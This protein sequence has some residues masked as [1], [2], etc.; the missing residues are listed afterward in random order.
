MIVITPTSPITASVQLDILNLKAAIARGD[1]RA[2]RNIL[3][4]EKYCV[5]ISPKGY[6]LTTY[7][8]LQT[9]TINNNT[10]GHGQS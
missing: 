3:N 6:K 10:K 2:A 4:G 9:S 8:K 5:P 1:E 7:K